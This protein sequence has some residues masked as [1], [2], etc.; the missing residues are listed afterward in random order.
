[1]THIQNRHDIFSAILRQDFTSFGAKVFSY[2]NP[3]TPYLPDWHTRATHYALE[4][5]RKAYYQGLILAQPPRSG[6]SIAASVAFPAFLHG[7][8]S[9]MR[10]ICASYSE[11]LAIKH[12]NDYRTIVKSDWYRQ[13]FPRTHRRTKRH[14]NLGRA[15]ERRVSRRDVGRRNAHWPGRGFDHH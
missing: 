6:K 13:L 7:H 15:L 12:H 4:G 8:R 3:G 11:A 2:L 9:S 1:M 14:R 10:I 5:I